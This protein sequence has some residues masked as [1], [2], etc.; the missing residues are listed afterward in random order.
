[1]IRRAEGRD[2]APLA[3]LLRALNT[4][5]GRVPARMTAQGVARDLIGDARVVVLL[6]APDGLPAGFVTGHP[7]YDSQASRWGCI[8]NDL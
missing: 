3:A 2:A 4:G 7:F 6:A 5:D 8:M 1:M